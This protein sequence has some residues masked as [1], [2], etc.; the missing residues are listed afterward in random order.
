MAS[1]QSR[2]FN[3]FLRLINKK[4]LPVKLAASRFNF[5]NRPEPP[6]KISKICDIHQSKID[7]FNVFTLKPKHKNSGKHILY[8][9]G[10][11]YT[12]NFQLFHWEFLSEL[13]AQTHCTITAP[14]YPLAP[15][16]TY[17]ESFAMV[18]PLYKQLTETVSPADLVLMGD[19]AGGGFALALAQ[20]MKLE[21]VSQPDQIILLSPWLDITLS[22]PAIEET[23]PIDPFLGKKKLQQA[24]LLY[25]GGTALDNPL[26]SPI[27][28]TLEGLGKISVFVGSKEILVADARK[29]KS[30]AQ[31]K[32][33]ALNYYE[34]EDMIHAWML[35]NFPESKKARQ[36]IT[37]IILR[38]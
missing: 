17:K 31:A 7:G 29:L 22:N 15:A 16:Y 32:G 30:M 6:L 34:Y 27:N 2:L 35:L 24:G 36:Q 13:V 28:G 9:H 33:V 11:A 37:A 19:S 8:L 21:Q 18:T 12:Q 3:I 14:D 23:E 5:Y 38:A 1:P 26:L 25:A 10:G 4:A 20:Q